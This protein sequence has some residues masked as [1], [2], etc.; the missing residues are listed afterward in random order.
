MTAHILFLQ[1]K[2][3]CCRTCRILNP[4]EMTI[5]KLLSLRGTYLRIYNEQSLTND[6]RIE[7]Y[8]H[9]RR[10]CAKQIHLLQR[11]SCDIKDCSNVRK[12]AERQW[13]FLDQRIKSSQT[14]LQCIEQITYAS[15]LMKDQAQIFDENTTPDLESLRRLVK[16][17]EVGIL[18]FPVSNQL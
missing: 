18:I 7:A 6:E 4:I 11:H 15:W 5:K 17:V 2:H 10:K 12:L 13:T 14:T 8:D 1:T 9:L 16:S 3:G